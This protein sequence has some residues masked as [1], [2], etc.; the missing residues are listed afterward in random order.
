MLRETGC[1]IDLD[2]PM[3]ICSLQHPHVGPVALDHHRLETGFLD[4]PPGDAGAQGVA[5]VRAKRGL[6]QP[7]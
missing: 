6:A 3:A 7:H 2:Q 4:Q 5:L 1:R